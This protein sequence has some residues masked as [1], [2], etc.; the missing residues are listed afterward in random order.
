MGR[1]LNI[2]LII[3]FC[4]G[5][6]FNSH[7]M[8]TKSTAI[9]DDGFF[10]ANHTFIKYFGRIDLSDTLVAKFSFPGV[11]IR[12]TFKGT[13]ILV[14][15]RDLTQG[16][17]MEDGRPARNFFNVYIDNQEPFVL[18]LNQT[19]SVYEIA[20]NLRNIKHHVKLVKRTEALV[21]KVAFKGVE[22]G[23]GSVLFEPHNLPKYKFEFI[24]NSVTCGYGVEAESEMEPFSCLTENVSKSYAVMAAER[25]HAE[26]NIVAYSG[27]GI[28]Q[29]Y[30]RSRVNTMSLIWQQV[31]P[32]EDGPDWDHA[33]FSPDIVIVNLGTNDF[34]SGSIVPSYFRFKY[35][36]FIKDLRATYPNSKVLCL[37]GPMLNNTD[38]ENGLNMARI[39]IG[40]VVR[41][42]NKAGDDAIYY[43]EL[44]PQTGEYGF[45]ANWHPSEEQ[46]KQ[47]AKEL[48][49]YLS[50]IIDR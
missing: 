34:F 36:E 42:L 7:D 15:M 11:N 17:I 43:F 13:K 23:S 24:G 40:S 10:P 39:I 50:Q 21:G 4:S 27:K 28:S 20:S 44:S 2:L 1:K 31:F 48:I 35:D 29:N 37:V 18:A 49:R 30:N 14:H 25:L 8:N 46:Q 19:D 45:G 32:D 26:Y 5:C 22:L 6:I 38:P 9:S 12:F 3:V 41:N 47:T 16:Q 33:K